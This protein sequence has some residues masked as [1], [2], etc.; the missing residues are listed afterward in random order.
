VA[1]PD[2]FLP[3]FLIL[4]ALTLF[5]AVIGPVAAAMALRFAAD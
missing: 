4:A 5:L 2:P 1:E 3:P